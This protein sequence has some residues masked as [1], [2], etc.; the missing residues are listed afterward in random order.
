MVLVKGGDGLIEGV[1]SGDINVS[2]ST[3]ERSTGYFR[4]R[5]MSTT[6]RIHISTEVG[7]TGGGPHGVCLRCWIKM[8]IAMII[9]RR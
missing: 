7:N 2:L 5:Q 3:Q 8:M 6:V 9:I 4:H 1:S